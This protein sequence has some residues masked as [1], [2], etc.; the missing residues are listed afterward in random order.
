MVVMCCN[1][2]LY[3]LVSGY[4]SLIPPL[5]SQIWDTYV[6]KKTDT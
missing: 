4:L 2:Y 6:N 1:C 3:S 5:E